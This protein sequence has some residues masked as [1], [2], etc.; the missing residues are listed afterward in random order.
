MR[1][2]LNCTTIVIGGGIQVAAEI[3]NQISKDSRHEWVVAASPQVRSA[4]ESRQIQLDNVVDFTASPARSRS[5]RRQVRELA[6]ETEPDSIFTVFGPAY[7]SF[8]QPHLCGV[9]DGWVTHAGRTAYRSLKIPLQPA[10]MIAVTIRKGLEYRRADAW[11]VEADSAKRG[12]VRRFRIS[13]DKISVVENN[14]AEHYF[15]ADVVRKPLTGTIRL[16]TFASAYRHKNLRI[17]PKV[18]IELEKLRPD[19]D[20]QFVTTVNSES[21][22]AKEFLRE[23]QELRIEHRIENLGPI[24]LQDG[25]GLY[26]SCHVCFMPTLLETFSASYPE[27]M[28]MKLPIVTTDIDFAHDICKGAAVYFSPFSPED[29]A[30]RILELV[31]NPELAENLTDAGTIRLAEFPH[32]KEKFELYVEILESL[33]RKS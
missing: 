14:C 11:V 32:P 16:L 7:T 4:L 21:P 17:I 27:A 6:D 10:R 29:A 9:A 12:L 26:E 33:A 22:V 28:A 19:F 15:R 5:A 18:A 3:C 13:E 30:R 1:F 20:F 2:L 25:P 8:E 23:C 31:D 24:L